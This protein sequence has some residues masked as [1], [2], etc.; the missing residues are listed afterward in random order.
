MHSN[1][2]SFFK[3]RRLGLAR[4][5]RGHRRGLKAAGWVSKFLGHGQE[6]ELTCPVY[7]QRQI[8]QRR[9]A[10]YVRAL[11]LVQQLARL[12]AEGGQDIIKVAHVEVH[13][14]GNK[15]Y[16][17]AFGWQQIVH[18]SIRTPLRAQDIANPAINRTS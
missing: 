18:L 10:S 14:C 17:L 8:L 2:V 15:S 3:F 4:E 13:C 1:L 9:A 12:G 5:A 16:V 6:C 7:G 11:R